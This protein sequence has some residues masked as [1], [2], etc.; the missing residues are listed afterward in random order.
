MNNGLEQY[1]RILNEKF[2]RKQSLLSF[3]KILEEESRQKVRQLED[4]ITENVVNIRNQNVVGDE[5]DN[6]RELKVPDFYYL[7]DPD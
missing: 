7:F 5:I 1:N 4:I 3:I 2:A 6:K